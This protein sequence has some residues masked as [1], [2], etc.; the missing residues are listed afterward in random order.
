MQSQAYAFRPETADLHNAKDTP[1]ASLELRLKLIRQLGTTFLEELG[2]F[3]HER[4]LD[5]ADG[6]D[7]YNEVRRFE[8]ELIQCA[9]KQTGG[10]QRAAAALLNL[11]PTTLNTKI[12]IYNIPVRPS[13]V[14]EGRHDLSLPHAIEPQSQT[15]SES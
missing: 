10:H 7:F 3:A 5:L 1:G 14:V 8:I 13:L 12:K 15:G 9:L 4:E 2:S 11:K 6:I